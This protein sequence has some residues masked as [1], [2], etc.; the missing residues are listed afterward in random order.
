[1]NDGITVRTEQA[2][3]VTRIVVTGEVDWDTADVLRD[4]LTAALAVQ[5]RLRGW[6]W[7]WRGWTSATRPACAP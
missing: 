5:P 6:R 2:S 1:M 7:T 3:T 4:A